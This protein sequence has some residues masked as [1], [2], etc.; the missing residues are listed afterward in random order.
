[1]SL[2]VQH[3]RDVTGHFTYCIILHDNECNT[4]RSQIFLRTTINTDIFRNIDRTWENIRRH[5]GNHWNRRV[6]VFFQFCT[7]N[8]VIC[9]YVKIIC[10]SRNCV[11][12]RDVSICSFSG[13][14][15]FYNFTKPLSFFHC[16]LCPHTCIQIS[17]LFFKEVERYHA[18]L[19]TSTTAQEQYRITF[20]DIE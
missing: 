10:V 6:K 12:F 16:F 19:H 11:I 15:N 3:W 20:G 2:I 8:R 4:G 18:E 14:S 13:R 1:M 9:G 5:I 7:V 17:S